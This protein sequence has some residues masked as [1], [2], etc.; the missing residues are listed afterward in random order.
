MIRQATFE[1]IDTIAEIGEKMFSESRWGIFDYDKDKVKRWLHY[2]MAHEQGINFVAE[3]AGQL[4]GFFIGGWFYS[5]FGEFK[6][7]T[8]ELLYVMPEHRGG[9]TGKKL[10]D[11]YVERAKELNVD[12]ICIGNSTGVKINST[13]KL[14]EY[15]GF[16][17]SGFNYF[18]RGDK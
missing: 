6:R 15:C 11:A 13:A 17:Q 9:T 5:Y 7:S 2:R 4:I 18:L 1:D 10:I 3:K 8:D 14:Y 16:S 12:D